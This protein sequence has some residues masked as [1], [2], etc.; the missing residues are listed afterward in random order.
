MTIT[1]PALDDVAL[2]VV[3]ERCGCAN[4]LGATGLDVG[5]SVSLPPPQRVSAA[6]APNAPT[7]VSQVLRV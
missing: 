6:P 5:D 4:G 7:A 1:R 3:D 2:I